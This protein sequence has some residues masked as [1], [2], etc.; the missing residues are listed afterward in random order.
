MFVQRLMFRVS[1]LLKA[2]LFIYVQMPLYLMYLYHF[3][4]INKSIPYSLVSS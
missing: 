4:I 3:C 2:L 1:I